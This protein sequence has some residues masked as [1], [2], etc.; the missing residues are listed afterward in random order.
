MGAIRL[1]RARSRSPVEIDISSVD[2]IRITGVWFWSRLIFRLCNG[3]KHSIAGL[4]KIF[5]SRFLKSVNAAALRRAERQATLLIEMDREIQRR[6]DGTAYVRHSTVQAF[7][8]GIEAVVANAGGQ[9]IRQH[10]EHHAKECL[11]RL[12]H[13]IPDRHFEDARERSNS[14]FVTGQRRNV[15]RAA[16]SLVKYDLTEEQAD[17]VSTDEDT[18]LVLAGAG[19]GKTAVIAAKIAYLVRHQ[20]MDPREILVLAF[21][22]KAAAEIRERLPDDLRGACVATFHAFGMRLLGEALD[23]KPHISKLAED[24]ASLRRTIDAIL[25]DLLT[26]SQHGKRVAKLLTLHRNPYRSPFDFKTSSEYWNHVRRCELR[27]L[28]GDLVKSLEEVQVAN[29]LSMNGI[30]FEYE[31]LYPVDTADARHRRYQ[32]DFHLPEYDVYI[33]HFAL[34]EAG[35]APSHFRNYLEGVFWK[36]CIH[37]NYGTTLVETY[38]WQCRQGVLTEELERALVNKGVVL[39]PVPSGRLLDRLRK[40]IESWLSGLLQTFLK[41]VKTSDLSLEDLRRRAGNTPDRA[42]SLAFLSVFDPVFSRYQKILKD[43]DA[44]DFED[45]VNQAAEHLRSDRCRVRYRYI[46]VDEFQDISAG[47]MKLLAS[48]NCPGTAYFLVGD[49]WQSIYRF[50]GSDVG[51]VRGSGRYLGHVRE[52]SLSTTFRYGKEI[53]GP[54]SGFVRRNPEQTQRDLEPGNRQTDLGITVISS[55]E[56]PQGVRTA[57]TDISR[58]ERARV[59]EGRA[60]QEEDRWSVLA[61]GR[62]KQSRNDLRGIPGS[63]RSEV[64]FSTVHGA[65]GRESDYGLVLDLK[66]DRMGFPFPDRGRPAP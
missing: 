6:F 35:K 38:S 42:R 66:D 52:R 43:E 37:R 55:W 11:A 26:S 1:G 58:R 13:L 63:G 59:D 18:T 39:R 14:R 16:R 25:L 3:Q 44:V 31:K 47:R 41:H 17:A 34:D 57:L 5:V 12:E 54:T 56:Q 51:L 4:R 23:R 9:L 33:E 7:R 24:P 22:R 48:L 46:L 29:F 20:K 21:N 60:E 30:R 50:A 19:T 65:K 62:Y 40:M 45:L 49:D 10:L 36:R 28:S 15:R 61:L 64:E 32:P 53:A 27:T 2:Q 8:E